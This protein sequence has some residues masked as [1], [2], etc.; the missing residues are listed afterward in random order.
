VKA[1]S[2]SLKTRNQFCNG[3]IK[4]GWMKVKKNVDLIGFVWGAL[5]DIVAILGYN[6][7]IIY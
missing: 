6:V 4:Y 7:V 1:A 3:F 2:D 5:F